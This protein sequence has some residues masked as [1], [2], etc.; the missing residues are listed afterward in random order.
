MFLIIYLISSS[1]NGYRLQSE[2]QTLVKPGELKEWVSY[3]ASDE[4][5]GRA[6]GSPEMKTA[7]LWIAEKFRENGLLPVRRDSGYILTY[8]YVSRQRT[9]DERNVIGMIEGTDPALKDKYIVLSAHFD[10]LG[11]RKSAQPDSI[12]NGADDNASG[13]CTLIGIA[14]AIRTSV[15]KPGRNIIFAA[16][17]GEESGERGSRYFVAN[18]PIDLKKIYVDLNFEMLGHSEYLGKKKYYM[19]GCLNSNLDNLIGEY[20]RKTDFTLID[21]ISIANSLFYGSDNISFSRI[22]TADGIS[23]GIPSGTF[24]TSTLAPHYHSVSDEAKLFDFE[25]MADL[26]NYFSKLVIWLSNNNSEIIWTDPKFS[27]L[28]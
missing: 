26:V 9:I 21:T 6:N 15:I 4:M 8:S 17:S 22:T 3:L 18:P 12:F 20:N 28:K 10:H 27:S 16:F 5:R 2:K 7:A 1:L 13:T 25:N 23:Q 19:T 24:A 11:V 14:K